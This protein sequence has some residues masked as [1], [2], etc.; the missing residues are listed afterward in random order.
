MSSDFES[1]DPVWETVF[2][3]NEWGKYPEASLIQ[4]IARNFYNK[5]E[6]NKVSLLEVGCGPG[7]NIWFMARE[8]FN[9]T[10]IDGSETAIK[11]AKERLSNESLNAKLIAGD[12]IKLPFKALEFDAVIDNECLY[13]NN[14]TNSLSILSEING[15]L[16]KDGLFYSRTFSNNMFVGKRMM[17][18]DFEFSNIT[19][20]P[21]SGKGF[22]RLMDEQ[23]INNIYGKYFDIISVDKLEYTQYNG[24]ELISEFIIICK[25]K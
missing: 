19:E 1:W 16:K 21:L 8:G 14:K 13:A 18:D 20:G 2:R 9:V 11:R 22:V 6:R 25:K 24:K 4:F 10:G 23:Q 3:E 17:K 15:V 7:A 12:I 5:K